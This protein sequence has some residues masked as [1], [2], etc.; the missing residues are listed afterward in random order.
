MLQHAL[1][2]A[3]ATAVFIASIILWRTFQL[4]DTV[5]HI[6]TYIQ[7]WV[8][9]PGGKA[10]LSIA[11]GGMRFRTPIDIAWFARWLVG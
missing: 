3:I 10:N 7:N 4:H 8:V 9:N 11:I 1:V 5:S 6:Y 2:M